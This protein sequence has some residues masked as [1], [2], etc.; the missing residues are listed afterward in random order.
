MS[1]IPSAFGATVSIN[2]KFLMAC[3]FG[4]AGWYI[5]PTSPLWWG[6]G[7]ASVLL[8]LGALGLVLN[9][10]QIMV[11]VYAREKEV[12]SYLRIGAPPKD[13]KMASPD[14]LEKAGMR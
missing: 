9:A 2:L 10:I 13:S 4:Y 7:V 6:L 8:W 1:P 12:R 11:R 3:G 5:W 14:E